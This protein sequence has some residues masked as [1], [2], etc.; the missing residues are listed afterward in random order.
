MV[1]R[2]PWCL[3]WPTLETGAPHWPIRVCRTRCPCCAL[4]RPSQWPPQY[5]G[6][7]LISALGYFCRGASGYLV[8]LP[9]YG[10]PQAAN[11][12]RF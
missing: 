8:F 11:P 1:L 5:S 10:V 12:G 4:Q 9:P 7:L 2:G 3:Q 6:E